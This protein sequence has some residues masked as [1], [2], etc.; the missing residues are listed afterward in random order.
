MTMYFIQ[1]D[2]QWVKLRS[3]T[4][5]S[6][7]VIEPGVFKSIYGGHGS[8]LIHVFATSDT[9]EIIGSKI[10]V[11]YNLHTQLSVLFNSNQ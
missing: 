10:I 9:N 4:E 11:S 5:Y 7:A 3:V 6:T 1:D 8:E 2:S